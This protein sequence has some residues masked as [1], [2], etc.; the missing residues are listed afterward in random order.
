MKVEATFFQL[1]RNSSVVQ[2]LVA[3][4]CS[5]IAIAQHEQICDDYRPFYTKF[6]GDDTSVFIT[7]TLFEHTPGLY[8]MSASVNG[9]ELDCQAASFQFVLM[10]EN[11][12]L[13]ACQY[14]TVTLTTLDT[15]RSNIKKYEIRQGDVLMFTNIKVK[16]YC[17]QPCNNRYCYHSGLSMLKVIDNFKQSPRRMYMDVKGRLERN[18]RRKKY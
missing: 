17:Y 18:G 3:I 5:N 11:K 2:L 15:L 7:Q 12:I 14:D 6:L 10:R 16:H 1:L 13:Y 8:S 4:L 9:S